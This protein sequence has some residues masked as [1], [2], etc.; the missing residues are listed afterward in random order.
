MFLVKQKFELSGQNL[1]D[2]GTIAGIIN[3]VETYSIDISY[4]LRIFIML[5]NYYHDIIYEVEKIIKDEQIKYENSDRCKEYT[6][7]VNKAL[8]NGFESLLKIITSKIKLYTDLVGKPDFDI[9]FNMIKEI[10]TQ[11][12]K[13]NINYKLYSKELL[14]LQEILE[15]IDLLKEKNKCSSVN[16]DKI[17][18]YFSKQFNDNNELNE[19]FEQFHTNLEKIF[20]KDNCYYKLTSIIFRNEFN[21]NNNNKEFKKKI[22]E[23]ITQNKEY[24]FNNYRLFKSILSFDISPSK[25]ENNLGIILDK[26]NENDLLKIINDTCKKY[27]FLELFVFNIYDYLFMNYFTKTLNNIIEYKNKDINKEDVE[28][29]K[30]FSE[31]PNET[32]ILFELSLTIF[33]DCLRFLDELNEN[34]QNN[35]LAKLY[36]ISYIKSYLYYLVIFSLDDKK[37]QKLGTIEEIIKVI[38]EKG[39]KFRFVVKIYL[40][41]LL[42]YNSKKINKNFGNFPEES[43]DHKGFN[44]LKEMLESDEKE[45]IREM[46]EETKPPNSE[47]YK[48]YPHFKYFVY[49]I[50]KKS[51]KN[52]F[53]AQFEK[54]EDYM[55]NYPIIYLYLNESGN[56]ERPLKCLNYVEKYNEFCNFMIDNFSFQKT[57]EEAKNE[58]LNEQ[59]IISQLIAKSG[60]NIVN[61]FIQIWKEIGKY[62]TE[63]K[64]N[65]GMKKKKLGL[66][67]PLVYFLND[68]NE[69]EYGMYIAAGYEHLIKLQNGFMNHVLKN[70]K[71]KPYL[72]L[73]FDHIQKKIPICEANNNQI[74]LINNQIYTNT[75]FHYYS[76]LINT[77]TRRK[78]NKDGTIDYKNYN[79]FEFDFQAIDEEFAKLILPGK[80]LFE[81]SDHLNFVNYWGEGFN[82]GETNFLEKFENKCEKT[83]ELTIEEKKNI[84]EYLKENYNFGDQSD[85]KK[86]YGNIQLL[87]FYLIQNNFDEGKE[88]REIF[89]KV[90]DYMNIGKDQNFKGIFEYRK[91]LKVNQIKSIFLFFEHLCFES[92]SSN[93]SDEFKK[94]IEENIKNLITDKLLKEKNVKQIAASVRRFISRYLY[95]INNQK[96]FLPDA[97]LIIQLKRKELWGKN[98]NVEEIL[99]S[100]KKL[101]L[102][103]NIEHSLKFYELIKEED[104]KEISD[105]GDDRVIEKNENNEEAEVQPK[106][107]KKK[108]KK[109]FGN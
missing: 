22:I 23:I 7:M 62:A 14:S 67:D 73:Y 105:F 49:S 8:F 96:E 31:L 12:N 54:Q 109:K 64:N 83:E 74:V 26:D 65:K 92:F 21:K 95:R 84:Y 107:V 47:E 18:T 30:K 43:L 40:L 72:K 88:L 5:S 39:N 44:C 77:F 87:I 90:P 60:K 103:F 108:M 38:N 75:E 45:M 70:G 2:F 106:K 68:V 42:Y 58:K 98:D 97:K 53:K 100:M 91:N 50:D 85:F 20:G 41:K 93:L 29:F 37:Q 6:S 56:K 34:E 13:F 80:C 57:R 66:D 19:S 79:S 55:N 28:K 52:I 63:Y 1:A 27:E 48:N 69:P 71:D 16:L 61:D 94:D 78:L 82:G 3:W 24:I 86:I 10:Y 89:E 33:G 46:V 4:I 59:S 11:V 101:G 35:H 17:L 81:D 15:I 25:M 9:F 99:E 104:E 36:A 102:D 51:E 76:E 32:G